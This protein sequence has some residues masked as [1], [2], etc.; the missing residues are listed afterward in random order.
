MKAR[1]ASN[2]ING[3]GST[4]DLTAKAAAAQRIA[5]V[6][7]KHFKMLKAECKQA[8]KAYKQARKAAK[9][10]RKEVEEA[11]QLVIARNDA[12][13]KP[14]RKVAKRAQPIQ[15]KTHTVTAIP[16]PTTAATASLS[17]GA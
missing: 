2:H 8:R 3:D 9:R 7:R 13:R 4:T 14:A 5:E 16:L 11:A 17:S 15:R 12:A 10:A 1:K 6:A